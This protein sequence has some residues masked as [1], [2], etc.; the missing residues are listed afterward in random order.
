MNQELAITSNKATA[1]TTIPNRTSGVA[2]V[3]MT[4]EVATDIMMNGVAT[5]AIKT[6]D[7]DDT[8]TWKRFLQGLM[9]LTNFLNILQ[10]KDI[11]YVDNVPMYTQVVCTWSYQFENVLSYAFCSLLMC[12]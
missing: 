1:G 8:N 11:S 7:G 10:K 6:T 4:A 5:V 9:F 3:T 2:T 12:F